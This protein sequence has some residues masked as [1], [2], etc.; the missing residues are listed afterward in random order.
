MT[1]LTTQAVECDALVVAGGAGARSLCADRSSLWRGRATTWGLRLVA[2][3]S[4][5]TVLLALSGELDVGRV[6]PWP[7]PT[8]GAIASGW[9]DAGVAR[10][11]TVY[12]APDRG[13]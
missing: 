4:G 7:G 9:A 11:R 12:G 10:Y 3:N 8:T 5:G 2:T 13:R 6:F 1:A